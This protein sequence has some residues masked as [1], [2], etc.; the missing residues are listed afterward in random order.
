MTHWYKYFFLL[1]IPIVY[2]CSSNSS[3]STQEHT[4]NDH[5]R[6]MQEYEEEDEGFRI[7]E[8]GDI[9][10]DG[11]QDSVCLNTKI[12]TNTSSIDVKGYQDDEGVPVF[13]FSLYLGKG[14]N[15]YEQ[16]KRC[17]I[18]YPSTETSMSIPKPG[19][20]VIDIEHFIFEYAFRNN[21]L[22]LEKHI[23]CDVSEPYFCVDFIKNKVRVEVTSQNDTSR[24]V[25]LPIPEDRRPS[26]AETNIKQSMSSAFREKYLYY[27]DEFYDSL[28]SS[29]KKE[30]TTTKMSVIDNDT[31]LKME[32]VRE[33]GPSIELIFM[34]KGL[35]Q[36]VVN[37]IEQDFLKLANQYSYSCREDADATSFEDVFYKSKST[38]ESENTVDDDEFYGWSEMF[39]ID[40]IYENDYYIS[41]R[42][43]SDN[44]N[45]RAC[46]YLYIITYDKG[47]GESFSWDM[48]RK[49]DNFRSLLLSH[50]SKKD[51][52]EGK[53]IYS[54]CPP[55]I[56][57]KDSLGVTYQYAEITEAFVEG[58]PGASIPLNKVEPFLTEEGKRFLRR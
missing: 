58:R 5:F 10:G 33:S 1:L 43:E 17:V 50:L 32:A 7:Y 51:V 52:E 28:M 4:E 41:Y 26:V 23:R 40:P 30:M 31:I 39:L 55:F 48:I 46:Y 3:N 25:T 2:G 19:R 14:N 36:K 6:S 45:C 24:Y 53:F 13:F 35:S 42:F 29:Y 56:C 22:Y 47:T 38:W 8:L 16:I 34:K 21:E 20:L 57:G 11:I 15:Q 54:D 12:V 27:G 44:S 49:D 18:P 37:A 9:N